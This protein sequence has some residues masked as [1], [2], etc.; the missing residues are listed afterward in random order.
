MKFLACIF[1]KTR[2]HGASPEISAPGEMGAT[3]L[4]FHHLAILEKL[5]SPW[6]HKGL[7]AA[8]ASGSR[9]ALELAFREAMR[10][11]TKEQIAE[12]AFTYYHSPQETEELLERGREEFT[13]AALAF[14]GRHVPLAAL[15][16]IAAAAP[17]LF[18]LGR[19]GGHPGTGS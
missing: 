3:A 8:A 4:T 9:K 5:N 7:A 17:D 15:P 10:G 19:P 6:V 13:T 1:G 11:V 18:Q 2:A 12:F 16:Q 14:L